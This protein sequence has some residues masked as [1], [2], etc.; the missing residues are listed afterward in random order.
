MI[1]C[2]PLRKILSTLVLALFGIANISASAQ[3]SAQ[4]Q[5][6][7]KIGYV[8]ANDVVNQAPQGAK[9]MELLTEEFAP[10]ETD[11]RQKQAKL[12]ELKTEL[13]EMLNNESSSSTDIRRLERMVRTLERDIERGTEELNEDFNIRRNEELEKLQKTIS[14]VILRLAEEQKFDLIVQDPVVWASKR[15]NLTDDILS[16][17]ERMFNQ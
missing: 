5:P 16:E 10:R 7:L 8:N 9:S 11:L 12:A 2:K 3:D 14:E 17:L 15:I 4:D 1:Q 6:N 13:G